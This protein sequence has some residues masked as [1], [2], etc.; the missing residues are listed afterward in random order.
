MKKAFI[1]ALFAMIGTAAVA[2]PGGM[3]GGHG[4]PGGDFMAQ[5]TEEQ[6]SCLELA[7][8]DCPKPQ[9]P[10]GGEKPAKGQPPAH[11]EKPQMPQMTQEQKAEMAAARECRKK[12]FETCGIEMPARPEK[13][14]DASERG[15]ASR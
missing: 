1:F 15:G 7:Q 13:P 6:K 2:A 4:G 5:L 12:A 10:N 11:G 3:P 14:N 8:A 9:M